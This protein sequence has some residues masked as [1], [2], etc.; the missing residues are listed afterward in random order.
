MI[1]KKVFVTGAVVVAFLLP[2][3]Q[4]QKTPVEFSRKDRL[5]RG[6]WMETRAILSRTGRVDVKTSTWSI[7]E[8]SGFHGAVVVFLLDADNNRLHSTTP[9]TYGVNSRL[10]PGDSRDDSFY[11]H[12]P[13]EVAEKTRGIVIEHLYRPENE[14]LDRLRDAREASHYLR[15]IVKDGAEVLL[16]AVGR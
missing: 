5:A 4:A 14:L 6:H 3:S 13:I 12:V 16:I 8:V 1:L 9:R 7:D 10:L 11:E 15:D 2:V